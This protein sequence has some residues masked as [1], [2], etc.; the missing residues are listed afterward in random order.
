MDFIE[1]FFQFS[2][3]G[4][5]GTTELFWISAIVLAIFGGVFR[6]RIRKFFSSPNRL[7]R[8]GQ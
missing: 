5:S 8:A 3:D 2:P 1:R 7:N 6:R 4:G